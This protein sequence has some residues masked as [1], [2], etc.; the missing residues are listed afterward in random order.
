MN[1]AL[2]RRARG[3]NLAADPSVTH[4]TV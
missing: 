1:R 2:R 3:E 4:A